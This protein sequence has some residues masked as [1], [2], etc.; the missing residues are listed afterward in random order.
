M[1]CIDANSKVNG[2]DLAIC[3]THILP[4]V[5]GVRVLKDATIVVEEDTI[6]ECGSAREITV[7]RGAHRIDG[8][9][10]VV[11]PGLINTHSHAAMTL[12]RGYADDLRL[13][14]WL[15]NWI[16]PLEAKMTNQDIATG[17]KLAAVESALSGSTVITSMYWEIIAEGNAIAEVGIR[18]ILGPPCLSSRREESI[19][20]AE[21]TVREL[22]GKHNGLLRVAISP[23]SP[24]TVDPDLMVKMRELTNELNRSHG[25]SDC[26]VILHTHLAETQHDW[27]QV[28]NQAK[29]WE[30]NGIDTTVIHKSSSICKY[31]DKLGIFI[32]E[33]TGVGDVLAAHCVWVSEKDIQIM[34]DRDVH[35]SH[36]PDS[37]LKLA[38]GIAPLP[39]LEAA[40]INISLGT[41]GASSNNTLDM[42]NAMRLTAILHKGHKLDPLLFPASRVLQFATIQGAQALLWK[43]IGSLEVGKK[44]DLITVDLRK[45]HLRPLHSITSHLVY[46]ANGS[47]VSETIVNGKLVVENK[48]VLTID[49][50]KLLDEAERTKDN[51]L[52]RLKDSKA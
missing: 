16:W 13:D 42:F 41:D 26:P 8:S 4:M 32:N 33:D 1:N 18:G 23:H 12:L 25:S 52:Q 36:N 38:S 43:D 21:Q 47:D 19:R 50:P 9:G 11:L 15:N 49:V 40:G 17:A 31:F 35:M 3:N 44:A 22:H 20:E 39:E 46:A 30:K 34:H 5:D 51:L 6:I 7:P 10:K 37:N 28:K 45:P 2:L 27:S 14:D 29:N 48:R 24:Y